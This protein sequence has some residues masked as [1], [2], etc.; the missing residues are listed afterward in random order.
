MGSDNRAYTQ[1]LIEFLAAVEDEVSVAR[2]LF[3]GDNRNLAAAT[4]ELGELAQAMLHI[5]EGKATGWNH[6]YTEAVQLAAMA[7]R[8]AIEGDKTI[9]C[10]LDGVPTPDEY[11]VYREEQKRL[12]AERKAD[13]ALMAALDPEVREEIRHYLSALGRLGAAQEPQEQAS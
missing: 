12:K 1:K 2:K 4:E 7:V 10:P 8:C 11:R 13:L 5:T 3:P 9:A 6:V